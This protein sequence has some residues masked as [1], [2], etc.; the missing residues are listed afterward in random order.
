MT[1]T[2]DSLHVFQYNFDPEKDGLDYIKVRDMNNVRTS[3]DM[4]LSSYG[5][6][7]PSPRLHQIYDVTIALYNSKRLM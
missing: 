4:F 1:K 2:C 5:T 3:Y 7:I 6:Q